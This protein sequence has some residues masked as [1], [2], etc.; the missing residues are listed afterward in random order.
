MRLLRSMLGYLRTQDSLLTRFGRTETQGSIP[1]TWAYVW[2]LVTYSVWLLIER[3]HFAANKKRRLRCCGVSG[4][5]RC[6]FKAETAGSSPVNTTKMLSKLYILQ[7]VWTVE[8]HCKN[9]C[10][11]SAGSHCRRGNH[12]WWFALREKQEAE[13]PSYAECRFLTKTG[14]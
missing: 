9:F 14:I 11:T 12:A 7:K 5:S 2:C 13:N 10:G 8:K 4:L 3:G 1:A 6:P